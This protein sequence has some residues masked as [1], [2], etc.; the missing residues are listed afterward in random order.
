MKSNGFTLVELI[1]TVSILLALSTI[2]VIT[3]TG[4]LKD[5]NKDI[6]V[7]Q[8]E[9][10]M[11][12]AKSY[13]VD[14]NDDNITIGKLIDNLYLEEDVAKKYSRDT[15]IDIKAY[16]NEEN[17]S[18]SKLLRDAIIENNQPLGTTPDFNNVATTDEG[19]IKGSDADGDTYYFRGAVE[20]NYVIID[21]LNWQEDGLYY[22]LDINGNNYGPWAANTKEI[23]LSECRGF[24]DIDYG[25]QSEEECVND[26]RTRG[27]SKG[28]PMLF[29]II[30][31][32]GNGTIRLITDD[33]VAIN[34]KYNNNYG[35]AKYVGYTYDNSNPNAQNGTSSTIKEKLDAWYQNNLIGFDHLIATT[36]YCNDTSPSSSNSYLGGYDRLYP[37]NPTPSFTC[38][39]T[40]N[41]Y[42]GEYNQKIGLISADEAV[43]AG[44]VFYNQ[45]HNYSINN[46]YYLY[47]YYDYATSTPY[48]TNTIMYI[49]KQIS[50]SEIRYGSFSLMPVIN[51][52]SN[53]KIS[54][55]IGT[56]SDPY[57]VVSQK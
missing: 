30:R 3:V 44:G 21:G 22:V 9:I 42:G 12:A 55:G 57:V 16:L 34:I 1:V 4:V 43:F 25:Y 2:A 50:S 41:T 38:P 40:T 53:V 27:Y 29:R 8:D 11:D 51:L 32:N 17:P 20:D 37:E 36:R 31:I 6:D 28:S 18:S 52:N 5:S 13:Y 49:S 48:S 15:S 33:R 54:G 39:Q 56:K 35:E 24:Y 14:T 10:V 19:L 26:I 46:K 23:A 45:N 47:K 7:V